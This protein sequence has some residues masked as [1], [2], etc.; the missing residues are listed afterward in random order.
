MTGRDATPEARV[1]LDAVARDGSPVLVYSRL[2]AMGEPEL[3]HG[4]IRAGASILELGSGA[5]RITHPL[6]ALGHGVTA[7]DDSPAMLAAIHGARTV[8]ADIASLDLAE[9]FD[10]VLLGSHLLNDPSSAPFL[11]TARRHVADDGLVLAEVYP[12]ELDWVARVGRPTVLGPVTITVTQATL[13][14]PRLDAE[15]AYEVDG[16]R[17]TQ[18]FVAVIRDEADLRCLLA[19]ADLAFDR[20]LERARGWLL[21]RP[22]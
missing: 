16:R 9:R 1:D 10:C 12:P 11:A 8:L 7:V 21:A 20:W 6:V 17:W 2:P 4:S 22:V 19:D 14:G 15:V 13:D 18:P 3:I 5:G